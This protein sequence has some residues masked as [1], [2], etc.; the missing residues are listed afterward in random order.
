MRDTSPRPGSIEPQPTRRGPLAWMASNAVAANLMMLFFIVGGLV[1]SRSV[2]QEVFPEVDLDI[3]TV[4]VPYPGASPEEVEEGVVLAIEEE[5]SGVDGIKRISST[6]AEGS[7]V[8]VAELLITTNPDRALADIKSAVDRIT[9]FPQDAERPIISL[10]NLR[11]EVVRVVVHGDVPVRTLDRLVEDFRAE[12]LADDRV[13]VAEKAGLPPPE[14]SI[15]VPSENLRRYGLTLPQIAQAVSAASIDLPAGSVKTGA[16]EVLVRT[17]ERRDY[18]E[19]F[20]DIVVLARPDGSRVRVRDIATVIDGYQDTD[21]RA[22]FDGEPAVELAVY[23]VGRESPIDVSDAVRELVEERSE[24]LPYS[25]GIALLNDEST[26]FRERMSLLLRNGLFGAVLVLCILGLFLEPRIA[27]WVSLGIPISFLGAFLFIPMAG[28]SINLISLFAFVLVLGIVVDDAVVVGEAIYHRRRAGGTRLE[29]AVDGTR[30]VLTPVVFAVLTTIIAF[31]PL[32]FVPGVTGKF[33]KNI[34]LIV[35]PI[36]VISLV[37]SLLILPAH[38][39]HV[40]RLKVRS[41]GDASFFQ[42]LSARQRRFSDRFEERV[43]EGM[44]PRLEG[45]CGRRYLVLAVATGLLV[46]SLS[47]VVSGRLKFN[48]FPSVEGDRIAATVQLPFGAPDSETERVTRRV[49]EAAEEVRAELNQE[50]E[51]SAE[52]V[53]D[54]ILMRVGS[55]SVGGFS[56]GG[57]QTQSGSHIGEVSVNLVSG[58]V[59]DTSSTEFIRRWRERVG[60]LAGVERLAFNF[61][62]GPSAGAKVSVQLSHNDIATLER[63][64]TRVAAALAEYPGVFDIDD[65]FQRGKPQLDLELKPVA[66]ALGISERDLALQ[67]RGAFFGA[68]ASR[69]QRGRD[70]VRTYVRLPEAE[71][72]SVHFIESLMIRTPG[73]GE[74]PLEEA[75][76]VER[77]RSFTEI[78]RLAGRRTVAV[79]ADVDPQVTTGSEISRILADDVLPQVQQEIAG[80]G[81]TF[82]GE[83]EEQADS[84]AAL[85]RGVMVAMMAMYGLMAVAFRSYGQPLVVLSVVPFG[86]IGAIFGHLV[87]GYDLSFLSVFGLVALT[88]VVVNDSLVLITAINDQRRAGVPVLEAVVQGTTRRV[89][90]VLLTSLTT[91]FGL[92]PMIFER[93]LQA[94][95][96]IPMV[97]SLGYGVLLVTGIAL[98]LV[99]CTY[100]MLE[101]FKRGVARVLGGEEEEEGAGEQAVA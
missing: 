88:G 14:I 73:G 84:V 98:V 46:V 3:V 22:F 43:E 44:P 37:E 16:G 79:T 77:G 29:A 51:G 34:P 45:L 49:L 76:Y 4:R 56:P 10:A 41:N 59:R 18:G 85:G 13:T 8:V 31:A 82:T 58:E 86:L 32:L 66:R 11:R 61:A 27:F 71:R 99:P 42:R 83:Q 28:I 15:E 25:V 75:A 26:N 62:D 6:A 57:I 74:I 63:A 48:F 23:R 19:E 30:E 80:L 92:A 97:L 7:G 91:F 100:M 20:G 81:F 35:I 2:K 96:L 95:F 68:E 17:T 70:E 93:S 36:L 50:D 55:T 39:A 53:V 21:E 89:R 9:S 87:M 47:F 72:D 60:E 65:G 1:F 38:L 69:Q 12:L 78:S 33:F 101:D 67:V 90:P 24:V 52:D 64:A 94:R 40:P 54:S 5:I